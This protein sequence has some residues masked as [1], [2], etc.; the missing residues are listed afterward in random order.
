MSY[1]CCSKNFSS[2]SCGSRLPSSG[3]SCGSAY[4]SNLVYGTDLQSPSTCQL[5]SSL[6]GGPQ[7]TCYVPTSCLRSCLLSGPCQTS[8]YRP[9]NSLLFSPR[10]T[11]YSGSLGFGS[12]SWHSPSCGSSGFRPLGYRV[13]GIPSSV[14]GSGFYRPSFSP[15]RI[16]QSS[17]YRPS[18][19]SGYYGIT[20]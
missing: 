18:C 16:F 20:C 5:R 14:Y 19:G 7:E 6:W 15:S 13:L 3:S 4:P 11:T 12:R 17:Y 8:C 10:Q 2:R 9:R 1:N